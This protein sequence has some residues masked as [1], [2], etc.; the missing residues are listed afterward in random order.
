MIDDRGRE[1][2]LR[3]TGSIFACLLTVIFLAGS[4]VFAQTIVD[5]WATVKA[6]PPPELKPVTIQNV[7]KTAFLVLDIVKQG[8]NNQRRPRCVTSVPKIQKFLEEA[9]AKGMP[10]IYSLGSQATAAD[11]LPEVAPR[12]DEPQVVSNSDKFVRTDLEKILKEKGI[13]TVIVVGTA[14]HGVVLYTASGSAYRG[15]KVIVP[16][17]GMSSEN[18]YFEQY[19]AYQLANLPGLAQAVTLTKFDLIRY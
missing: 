19:V 16:V 18:T 11:I 15:F 10:V 13:K 3:F 17:D 7:K 6:P 12:P 14:A 2:W 4:P 5:E 1:T 8:C 9:R